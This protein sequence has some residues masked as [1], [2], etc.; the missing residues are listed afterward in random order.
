MIIAADNRVLDDPGQQFHPFYD[1]YGY[2]GIYDHVEIRPLE[3]GIS[4]VEV[5][6]LSHTDGT[7][8]IRLECR[9]SPPD[10]VRLSFDGKSAENLSQNRILG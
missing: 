3:D 10:S 7:V 6:P 2:G 5:L 9:K 8:K 1:F 4:R